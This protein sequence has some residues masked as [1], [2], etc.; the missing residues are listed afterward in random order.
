MS[1]AEKLL[2]RMRESKSGWGFSDL[3]SL[4]VGFGFRKR[5]GGKHTIYIHPKFPRLRATVARHRSLPVGYIEH[6][7]NLIDELNS[8][9]GA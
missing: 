7:I 5:E 6:A 3:D 2:A 9:E 4:Y 8:F 1:S